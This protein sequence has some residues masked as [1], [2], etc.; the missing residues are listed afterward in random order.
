MVLVLYVI[1]Y[2]YSELIDIYLEEEELRYFLPLKEYQ[3]YCEALRL[4]CVCVCV[5]ACACV[6][7]CAHVHASVCTCMCV[8]C[9]MCVY[10]DIQS[11]VLLFRGVVRRQKVLQYKVEKCEGQLFSKADEKER[12]QKKVISICCDVFVVLSCVKLLCCSE[13]INTTLRQSAGT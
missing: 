2:S 3:S 12:L 8:M 4:M 5:C 7:V 9:V 13:C 10:V 11:C 6:C 1:M